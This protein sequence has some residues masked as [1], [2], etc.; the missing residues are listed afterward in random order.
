VAIFVCCSRPG[1]AVMKALVEGFEVARRQ[2][3]FDA[4]DRV[5]GGGQNWIPRTASI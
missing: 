4:H 1:E 3:S 5:A 2:V